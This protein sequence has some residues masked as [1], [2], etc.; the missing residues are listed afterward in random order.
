MGAWSARDIS[1]LIPPCWDSQG[2]SSLAEMHPRADLLMQGT[3][4]F[5][6]YREVLRGSLGHASL[7]G[8]S[9][10]GAPGI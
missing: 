2:L 4:T 7:S 5:L 6:A 10:A 9:Q 1:G 8:E 3:P